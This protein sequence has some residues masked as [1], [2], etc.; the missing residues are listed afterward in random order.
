MW[1]HAPI[2][3]R[4]QVNKTRNIFLCFLACSAVDVLNKNFYLAFDD[5]QT[6]ERVYWTGQSFTFL[7]YVVFIWYVGAYLYTTFKDK[8]TLLLKLAALNWIAFAVSDF[9]DEITGS[10]SDVVWFEYGAFIITIILT[11][12]EWKRHVT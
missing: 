3:P 2:S 6:I 8:W 10:A 5:Q 1:G 7:C 9:I 11:I 12:R 4:H